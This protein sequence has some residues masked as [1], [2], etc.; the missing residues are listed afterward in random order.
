[1]HR[2]LCRPSSCRVVDNPRERCA[3][4]RY[5][6][7]DAAEAGSNHGMQEG[8]SVTLLRAGEEI[9]HPI[10]GQVLGIPQEPVGI[11]EVRSV[12]ANSATAVLVK[13]YSMPSVGDLVE[14]E[15]VEPVGRAAGAEPEV[16][17]QVIERV[18][19]LEDDSKKL[20]KVAKNAVG[21]SGIR[22]AG[23]G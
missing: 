7:R 14:Y 22:A 18:R 17:A 21:L 19:G 16:V 20:S 23:V 12:E 9:I 4:W 2:F 5:D 13:T 15:R 6:L 11:A 8:A 3:P 10:S 1:M